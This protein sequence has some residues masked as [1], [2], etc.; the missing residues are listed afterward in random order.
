MQAVE[1]TQRR[2]QLEEYFDRTAA[3][4]WQRLTSEE[5]VGRIRATIRAGRDR[6]A[7]I[8]LGCLPPDLRGLRVLDAGCGTGTLATDLA[9][10]GASVVAVDIS[11]SLVD[12]ARR[13]AADLALDGIEFHV[14]DMLEPALG[15]FDFI[16]AFDSLIH[17]PAP[18]LEALLAELGARARRGLV[19]TFAPRTPLL[20][21]MHA[22]GKLFPRGN[23]SP[24]IRPVAESDLRRRLANN[25]AMAGF[26][27]GTCERVSSGFY[28]SQ[29]MELRRR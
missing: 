16:I 7:A 21:A 22:V 29:A 26:D 11:Q 15:D 28:T 9:R 3:R 5:P 6:M 1:Y 4:A 14:G 18:Q 25:P 20:S 24:D 27:V 19:F 23:R 17:Y 2:D 13:R 12:M 10:M 8:L